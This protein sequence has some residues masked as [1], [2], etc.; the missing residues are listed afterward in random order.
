[1]KLGRYRFSIL[2]NILQ[3]LK[4]VQYLSPPDI[5]KSIYCPVI[6]AAFRQYIFFIVSLSLVL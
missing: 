2:Y 6:E 4:T 5:N 1:M 3:A